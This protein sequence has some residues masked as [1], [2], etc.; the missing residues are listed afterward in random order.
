MEETEAAKEW[1]VTHEGKQFGPVSFDDMIFEKERGELDPRLDMVWKSGM[2]DWIPA[3]D[4]EGLFKRNDDAK[5][6]ED[7]K[8]AANNFTGYMP[9]ETEE[10]R[11][12]IKGNWPGVGRGSFFFF[13]CIFPFLWMFGVV[14]AMSFLE[15]KISPDI[16]ILIPLALV[17][18]PFTLLIAVT[19]KRFQNLGM[20]RVWF[21][22]LFVP[23]LSMWVK[24]RT[25]ACPPGYAQNKKLDGLGWVLAILYWLP[26]IAVLVAIAGIIYLANSDPEK[27]KELTN[28][29]EAKQFNEFMENA[30]KR[31]EQLRSPEKS[32]KPSPEPPIKPH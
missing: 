23:F 13:T 10:E 19:L 12:L 8:A 3:G 22:G 5:S 18:V 15:G 1:F 29:K 32:E 28:G 11:K 16:Q 26:S 21:L 14:F 25:F 9:G 20:S 17:L 4:V 2:A 7:A 24:Y 30:R 27:F 31:G 6:A